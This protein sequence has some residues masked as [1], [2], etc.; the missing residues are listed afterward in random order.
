ML[1]CTYV[2]LEFV[3]RTHDLVTAAEATE[4]E[5]HAGAQNKP[6][7]FTAGVDFFHCQN[8]VYSYIQNE[9]LRFVLSF[10]G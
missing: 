1:N 8:V 9:N 6:S 5:V 10:G 4:L 3:S 2:P 7:L